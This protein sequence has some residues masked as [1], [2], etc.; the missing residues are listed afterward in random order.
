[1]S[2]ILSSRELLSY[3]GQHTSH[4]AGDTGLPLGGYRW[5]SSCGGSTVMWMDEARWETLYSSLDTSMQG[6]CQP[7][8]GHQDVGRVTQDRGQLYH[9]EAF[10]AGD[11]EPWSCLHISRGL[12]SWAE[13]LVHPGSLHKGQSLCRC[14]TGHLSGWWRIK[15]LLGGR[16]WGDKWMYLVFI[17]NK[18]F[19]LFIHVLHL[20]L[21][22]F[23][24]FTW[25]SIW[26]IM[27]MEFKLEIGATER[28]KQVFLCIG[29]PWSWKFLILNLSFYQPC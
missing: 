14:E 22:H 13:R 21:K 12:P 18:L 11:G 15:A 2:W 7:T 9:W 26:I 28:M 20:S 19:S 24:L 23:K 3:H 16:L 17:P 25:N 5:K 8:G 4:A 29:C 6:G 27:L 10:T 1:M